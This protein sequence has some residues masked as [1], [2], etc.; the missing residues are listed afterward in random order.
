MQIC[1]IE[2]TTFQIQDCMSLALPKPK[3][4]NKIEALQTAQERQQ[5]RF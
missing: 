2:K 5:G 4:I 1:S 3:N